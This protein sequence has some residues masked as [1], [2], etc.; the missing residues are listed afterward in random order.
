MTKHEV[1]NMTNYEVKNVAK[2]EV[3]NTFAMKMLMHPISECIAKPSELYFSLLTVRESS[4]S[5]SG[6]IHPSVP[7]APERRENDIRPTA[8]FLH[9][10]K[11]DIMARTCP[12]ASGIEMSTFCGF[13]SRCTEKV[14]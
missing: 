1:K 8:N 4:S 5:I 10:P 3:K 7:A 13:T 11:S 9:K 12:R 14:K 2:Y 6:A